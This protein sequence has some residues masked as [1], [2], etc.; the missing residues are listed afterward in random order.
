M[1]SHRLR[2][3]DR[4]RDAVIVRILD[5]T[6]RPGTWLEEQALAHEL[7]VSQPLVREALCEIEVAG[8]TARS[9]IAACTCSASTRPSF[10]QLHCCKS[11]PRR[12]PR[13]LPCLV[14]RPRSTR[15]YMLGQG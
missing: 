12:A 15:F 3:Q 7:G 8:L 2:Q 11:Q 9:P 1:S 14:R 10:A 13:S 5:G 6:F 4:G